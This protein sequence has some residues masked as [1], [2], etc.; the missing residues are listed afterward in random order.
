[1]M[2]NISDN[3]SIEGELKSMSTPDDNADTILP[4][5]TTPTFTDATLTITYT[6]IENN[7][8]TIIED[9]NRIN[10]GSIQILS[11][12]RQRRLEIIMC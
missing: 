8:S 4:S 3:K 11:T 1:M 7:S 6:N 12:L 10:I 9:Q 5:S 2:P